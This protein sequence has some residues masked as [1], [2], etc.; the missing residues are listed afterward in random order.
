M[1]P[2]S[3]PS[4]WTSDGTVAGTHLVKNINLGGADSDPTWLTPVGNELFFSADAGGLSGVELHKTD[5][6]SA[7]T[8]IFNIGT[9]GILVKSSFPNGIFDLHGVAAFFANGQE[10]WIS[11]GT[12]SGTIVKKRIQQSLDNA[13]GRRI[14]FSGRRS[15]GVRGH[16]GSS[17]QFAVS[18]RPSKVRRGQDMPEL[19]G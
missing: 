8:Q 18:E 14:H 6:T 3:D 5:G 9:V 12:L 17:R 2:K 1:A 11:D 4:L 13:A 19:E 10:S 7:G 15:P 16:H